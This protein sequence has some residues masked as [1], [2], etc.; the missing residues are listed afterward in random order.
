[1]ML[2]MNRLLGVSLG[3]LALVAACGSTTARGAAQI[4][5]PHLRRDVDNYS[6]LEV[7]KNGGDPT[8][9]AA[10]ADQARTEAL[11]RDYPL[12]DSGPQVHP[13]ANTLA[14]THR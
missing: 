7:V 9:P 11:L 1:M 3:L 10:V 5:E 4:Q 12:C 6:C 8:S 13:P 14:T 2:H